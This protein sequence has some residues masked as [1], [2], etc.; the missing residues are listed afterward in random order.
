MPK[1]NADRHDSE[2]TH[3]A[4]PALHGG[5]CKLAHVLGRIERQRQTGSVEAPPCRV[6]VNTNSDMEKLS[7]WMVAKPNLK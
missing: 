7:N 6:A 2:R 1:R 3:S 5:P 4:L